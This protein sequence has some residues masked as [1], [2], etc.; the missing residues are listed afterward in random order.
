M[1]TELF[2]HWPIPNKNKCEANQKKWTSDKSKLIVKQ[3]YISK[4]KK[5][6]SEKNYIFRYQNLKKNMIDWQNIKVFSKIKKGWKEKKNIVFL[7]NSA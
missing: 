3:K 1:L 4:V 7:A 6:F 5:N 2:S